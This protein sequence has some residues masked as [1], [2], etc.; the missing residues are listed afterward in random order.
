MDNNT[1]KQAVQ[2]ER[3]VFSG[4]CSFNLIYCTYEIILLF[5]KNT[6]SMC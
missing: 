5:L 4:I 1:K 3:P 6:I 2:N